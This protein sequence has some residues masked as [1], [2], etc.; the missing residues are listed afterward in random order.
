MPSVSA[1]SASQQSLNLL[2]KVMESRPE[3][4]A[5]TPSRNL[6]PKKR[7]INKVRD[8]SPKSST[9]PQ[10]DTPVAAEPA[11]EVNPLKDTTNEAQT[12][13][14]RSPPFG[15]SPL[16]S[17]SERVWGCGTTTDGN[18]GAV[19]TPARLTPNDKHMEPSREFSWLRQYGSYDWEPY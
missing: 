13:Q 18:V 6:H 9:Q 19:G 14:D 12:D 5:R 7:P 17:R 15:Q 8:S 1:I 3:G 16:T 4:L 10:Q 11:D 2:F